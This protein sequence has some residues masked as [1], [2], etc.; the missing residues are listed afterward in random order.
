MLE[1]VRRQLGAERQDRIADRART[2]ERPLQLV[3]P[4]LD[5]PGLRG[6]WYAGNANENG[7][8]FDLT[9]QGRTLTASGGPTGGSI[10]GFAATVVYNGTTQYHERADEAGL[11]ITG[12]LTLIFA[13]TKDSTGVY[14]ALL[15]KLSA[16][17][18][19]YSYRLAAQNLAQMQVSSDGTALTTVNATNPITATVPFLAVGRFTPSTELAIFLSGT[20]TRNTT[21]I[22]AAAFSGNSSLRLGS[23]GTNNHLGGSAAVAAI[24]AAAVGDAHVSALWQGVRGCL[25]V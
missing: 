1:S 10:N 6:L 11:D 19:N 3:A 18:G 15:A 23:D 25:G 22:P 20:W 4:F 9:G 16:A 5:L 17:A 14:D 21:A 7:N 2:L 12:A 24:C 13:G 8:L